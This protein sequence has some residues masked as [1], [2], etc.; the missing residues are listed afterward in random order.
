MKIGLVEFVLLLAIAS[1]AVGPQVALWVNR[2]LRRAQRTNAAAARRRAE[3]QAQFAEER[4]AVLHRFRTVS[5]VIIVLIVLALI[6]W[7]VF[8]PID[9]EPQTYTAPA[10]RAAAQ[11]TAGSGGTLAL[12]GYSAVNCVHRQDDWLY[13]AVKQS[14]KGSALV[15]VRE[16]G[17]GLA[18]L[19]T[20]GDEITG[21]DFDPQ[22]NIWF[23]TAGK[24]GG[25]LYRMSYDGW[26]AAA[27]QV[28]SQIDGRALN[29][30]T[31]VAVGQD[32]RVYFADASA[33]GASSAETALRTELMAHTATGWVYVYDPAARTVQRVLGGLAGASG[34]ALSP[35]GSTLYVSDLG[36]RCIWAVDA[37][38]KELTAGGRNCR[39]FADELPGYPGALAVDEDGT[40]YVGYCWARSSWLEDHAGGT[41]LRGAALRLSEGMQAGLFDLT[42]DDPAAEAFSPE[43]EARQSFRDKAFGSVSALCPAGSRVYLG[44]AG[45]NGLCYARV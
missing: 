6:Y 4:E 24:N 29:A 12:S 8:R 13:A 1:V 36:S 28:V 25:G 7:L 31:A 20:T 9:A 30:P 43:G 10:V 44:V 41:L 5:S 38:A 40:V 17:S 42:A 45:Q 27:E 39:V 23:V 14:K 15:R 2:W 19:L 37:G 11:Q 18:E 35:D 22:G 21:F 32:G 34:L 3:Y 26:G 16:D 33:A